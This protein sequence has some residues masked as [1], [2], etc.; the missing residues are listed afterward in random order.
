MEEALA[1]VPAAVFVPLLVV[2]VT[3]LVKKYVTF[4]TGELTVVVALVVG[5]L[6]A[7][8]DV[9]I[10]VQDVSIAQGVV[11]AAGA[12]GLNILAAK[13]GGGASGDV[14]QVK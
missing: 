5:A 14:P 3:Q 2:A 4:V 6:A 11:L 13:A 1:L 8:V 9:H 7:L 12:V 10:G